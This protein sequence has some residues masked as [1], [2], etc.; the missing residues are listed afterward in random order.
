MRVQEEG[1]GVLPS[2]GRQ[3]AERV[4]AISVGVRE[5]IAYVMEHSSH[6][7]G[8]LETILTDEQKNAIKEAFEGFK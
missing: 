1:E 7:R 4:Y 6:V 5:V 8:V 3:V 2:I